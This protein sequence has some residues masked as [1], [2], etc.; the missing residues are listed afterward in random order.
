MK[1][2]KNPIKVAVAQVAPVFLDRQRTIDKSCEVIAEAASGGADLIAFPEA[3]I[4]GY[5]DWIWVVPNNKRAI[6]DALYIELLENAVSIPDDATD[7][8]CQCAQENSIHVVMGL[9]ERNSEASGSS[10][11]NSLLYIDGR[12]QV[13]GKH[14]KLV[15]T[16]GERLVWAPGDGSTL[17]VFETEVGRMGGL[18]CWENYMPL[19]RSAYY[20]Q[21]IQIQVASTWDSSDGWLSSLKHIAKEGG[22]F[23][24][25]CC[26]AMQ[27][28]DI[29]DAYEFKELYPEGK[30]WINP[31]N[32]CIIGP[33]GK[34]LA[35]PE[36]MKESILYADIDFKQIYAA[37]RMFDVS[38]HYSR[39]DVFSFSVKD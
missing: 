4:P 31:G 7:Q 33:D 10:V 14:R 19:A 12:G 36:K 5:P 20:A 34:F 37:K 35:G 23:V 17:N 1:S 21:G 27:M 2:L 6:L 13:I 32:S 28:Q 3:F 9:H 15:P 39:P 22:M 30:D 29:P 24:M 26:T 16:G 18:I 11:Y 25:G 8:L 38:G